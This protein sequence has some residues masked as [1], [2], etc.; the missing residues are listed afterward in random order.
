MFIKKHLIFRVFLAGLAIL[1]SSLFFGQKA[2]AQTSAPIILNTTLIERLDGR[3]II[4]DGLIVPNNSVLIYI[5]GFYYG[6]A[7]ISQNDD[8]WLNFSYTSPVLKESGPFS[9]FAIAKNPNSNE[10]SAIVESQ[11]STIIKQGVLESKKEQGA[12]ITKPQLPKTES[13]SQ[14]P[15]IDLI[16]NIGEYKPINQIIPVSSTEEIEQTTTE[17]TTNQTSTVFQKTIAEKVDQKIEKNDQSKKG[18]SIFNLIIFFVFI[19]IIIIWIIT[20]SKSLQKENIKNVNKKDD[21]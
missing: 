20:I 14:V 2:L 6:L 9:V 7:N 17:N 3:Q 19:I 11:I 13:K 21:N 15:I 18:V 16:E 4:V 5:N 8:D 12:V 1:L 10:L